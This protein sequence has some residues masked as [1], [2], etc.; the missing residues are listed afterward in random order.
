MA[1]YQNQLDKTYN[2]KVHHIEFSVGDV[3]LVKVVRNTKDTV[4][5]KLDPN[6]EGLYKIIKLVDKGAYHFEDLEGK[7]VPRH[8]KSNNLK[9]YYH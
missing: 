2:Q 9:K 1:S 6:W 7:Q 4:D 3:V 5:G 8:W